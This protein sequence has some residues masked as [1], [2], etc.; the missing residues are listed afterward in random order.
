MISTVGALASNAPARPKIC[1]VLSGGGARGFAHVGALKA[2]EDMRIRLDCIV[3]TSMGAVVGGLY[4]SGLSADEITARFAA[5]DWT[6]LAD[7]R[8]DRTELRL[9]QKEIDFDYPFSL[10]LG[11][12]DGELRL[13]AG[14]VGGSRF[15]LTLREW[16][17]PVA[18]VRDFDNL[19]IQY[20]SL[21]TDLETGQAVVFREGRLF[22]A[23]RAS[24]SVPGLFAP[25][26]Q[27]GRLLADGGLVRNLPVD[28]A[29][30]LGADVIIAINIGSPLSPRSKLG[31]LVG[32]YQQ[33]I[34]ILTEQNVVHQ[35]GLLRERDLL[36]T[37]DLKDFSFLDFANAMQLL[38]LG[39]SA[40]R[41]A[42]DRLSAL[43]LPAD[44]Y[45]A[46]RLAAMAPR[47]DLAPTLKEVRI[48]SLK[49]VNPAAYA[50][51]LESR[52]GDRYDPAKVRRD[53]QRLESRGDF[54]RIDAQLNAQTGSLHFDAREKSW[55]PNYLRFG[56]DL[57]TDFRGDGR[58]GLSIG[59]NR[60][61]INRAGA[62]WRTDL[63]LGHAQLLRTEFSQPL[64]ASLPLYIAPGYQYERRP[65]DLYAG[66]EKALTINLLTQAVGLRLGASLGSWGEVRLGVGQQRY[67]ARITTGAPLLDQLT[68]ESFPRE[69]TERET[70]AI[71]ELIADQL[72]HAYFPKQGYRFTL[73]GFRAFQ[74]PSGTTSP[75][76]FWDADWIGAHTWGAHTV[77]TRIRAASVKSRAGIT[78]RFAMGGFQEISGLATGQLAGD[79]LL[80]GR[81]TYYWPFGTI[82]VFGRR[83]YLGSSLEVGNVWEVRPERITWGRLR[84]AGS[85][86]LGI[87]TPLGPAYVAYGRAS[88]G[89]G[90]AYLFLG[91]P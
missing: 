38:P 23:I 6:R 85:I 82:D 69:F 42:S 56:L 91:R 59:H 30:G 31:S 9:R 32:V 46:W 52:V 45:A 84:R 75:Y 88:G 48:T 58:F 67:R 28:E 25:V 2:L 13:P 64:S 4:A 22:E 49:A 27:Q 15:E 68:Q 62:Q 18:A 44:M 21:S 24:M 12:R 5:M 77:N 37:P 70:G 3:G 83:A 11:V 73:S 55:G 35:I 40:V 65:V 50:G 39:E 80:F 7:D 36:I 43:S 8:I 17:Q 34:N 53:L 74:K 86:F 14:V 54:E 10:E 87:D 90:A 79:H 66:E 60:T 81:V 72:D 76:A 57:S 71:G 33:M 47:S 1:A 20:R 78:R 26:E 63:R 19:P 29:R 16:L 41:A 51:L 89:S 61:W